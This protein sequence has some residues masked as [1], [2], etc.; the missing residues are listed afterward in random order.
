MSLGQQSC[1]LWVQ[2]GAGSALGR[3]KPSSE[4]AQQREGGWGA[5]QGV[6]GRG[7]KR[8]GR[9]WW[10]SWLYRLL[11]SPCTHCMGEIFAAGGTHPRTQCLEQQPPRLG[12]SLCSHRGCP[13]FK[14][15]QIRF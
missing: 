14:T 11:Q 4:G 13:C 12:Q 9:G 15:I 3:R 10:F 6:A 7:A 1:C 5:S 2:P 8:G